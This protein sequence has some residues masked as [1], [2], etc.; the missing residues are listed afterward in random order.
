[1]SSI[2]NALSETTYFGYDLAGRVTSITLPDSRVISKT[3]NANGELAS[4]TPPGRPAHAF[5]Y[6]AYEELSDYHPPSIG[7]S[8]PKNTTYTYNG[9]KK[10]TLITLPNSTT[11]GFSY[12]STTGKLA[13]KTIAAGN[14]VYQY[15]STTKQLEKIVS[16]NGPA[17]VFDYYGHGVKDDEQRRNSDNYLFG[18]VAFTF[19]SEHRIS[20]RIT[21]PSSSSGASTINYS[22]NDD[23]ELSQVGDLA[24][25]Y[26]YPSGR[27][28]TTTI[29]NIT[30]TRTYDAN[31]NLSTYTATYTPTSTVLYSYA[32]TRDVTSRI[33]GKSE[34]V[35]GTTTNY[36]YSYDSAGRLT[37]MSVNGSTTTTFTYDNNSNRTSGTIDSVAFSAT[38]DDQDRILTYNSRT[39]THNTNGYLTGIQW[40]PSTSSSFVYDAM[41]N[42]KQT[43][44]TSGAVHTFDH[45][46]LDRRV[47]KSI[48]GTLQWRAV[49]EN[50]LRI[51]AYVNNTAGILAKEF[52]YATRLNVPDYMISGGVKYRIVTDHLG[53]PRLM[54]KTTDGTIAQRMDYNVL[55][56]VKA[57]TNPS[58]QPFGFAGGIYEPGVQLVRFGARDY[59][60]RNTGRWTTKDPIRFDGGDVNLYGYVLS[61]PV[62]FID[63]QGRAA[64]LLPVVAVV[65]G[66]IVGGAMA[67]YDMLFGPPTVSEV[68][69]NNS[70]NVNDFLNDKLGPQDLQKCM[71]FRPRP[72]GGDTKHPLDLISPPQHPAR[73]GA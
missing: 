53:S 32:L 69:N 47:T 52:V 30:D 51:A 60:P 6:N 26:S 9:D 59:D 19:D 56:E 63:P 65:G 40:T 42:L 45:D 12:N 13:T 14:Y 11:I 29:G 43:T 67:G 2:A 49:Y 17:S 36:V 73:R 35:L 64:V 7:V 62:N 25:T 54:V 27:L 1:M 5:L 70:N 37:A 8:I 28:S 58:F 31:G 33:I 57:D 41:G 23:D 15:D 18:K 71:P 50:N 10:V 48:G 72:A 24:L 38:Y 55:G 20:S 46:G 61:D 66:A 22:Y 16:P 34:N 3:Y 4:I 68:E 21:Q 39:Y 44:L